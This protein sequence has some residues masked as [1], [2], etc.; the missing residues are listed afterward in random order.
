MAKYLI[1][2]ADDFG[3]SPRVSEGIIEAHQRG[4]V[5][6]TSVMAHMPAAGD[7]IR[8]AQQEA[9][10]LGLGLHL[11]LSFGPPA[12]PAEEVSSLVTPEGTF[13]SNFQELKALAPRFTAADLKT[14]YTA[15][16]ERFIALAGHPPDH[17]DSHHGASYWI[18]AAFDVMLA[19]AAQYG[20]PI[21]SPGTH[22]DLGTVP[23]ILAEYDSVRWPQHIT[24]ALVFFGAGATPENLRA[25]LSDLPDGV[26]EFFCHPGYA[27]DLD[28]AYA[29]PRENELK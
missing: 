6:S 21:R 11:T 20:L 10:R 5:T 7:A 16:M 26:S 9:P 23:R 4:I 25:I 29:A 27:D 3:I 1:V 17:L 8:R 19:L 2:N 12:A 14:E 28:E 15:Q 18:A 24:P 13:C 22:A